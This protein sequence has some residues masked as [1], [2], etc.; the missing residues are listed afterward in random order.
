MVKLIKMLPDRLSLFETVIV[1][2]NDMLVELFLNKKIRFTDI[3]KELFN[4]IKTKKFFKYKK[5]YP[6]TPK[7]IIDL[8]K[9]VRMKIFKKVYKK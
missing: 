7:D 8:N 9:Y 4:L 6:K 5:I 3:Q 2:A 1:S